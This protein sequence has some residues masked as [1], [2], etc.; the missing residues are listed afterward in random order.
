MSL[1]SRFSFFR[2]DVGSNKV[3]DLALPTKSTDPVVTA[4][5]Q[6]Q[7]INH[8]LID[9]LNT[10]T[11][12][13]DFILDLGCHVGTFSVPAAVLG[14]AVASLDAS[15]L[16]VDALRASIARNRLA[17]LLVFW[18]AVSETD[19]ELEFHENGLWGMV[20]RGGEDGGAERV[21]AKRVDSLLAELAWP[22]LDLVKMD[23]EGSEL[24]ALRSMSGMLTGPDA[25]AV[26]YE[27]NGMTFEIFKYSIFD[28][29]V[30]LE[31]HGYQT[32][33][34]EGGRFVYCPPEQLQPEAWL[35]VVALPPHWRT[36]LREQIVDQ[37]SDTA[38]TNRCLEWGASE[39]S[40][41]RKYLRDAM[42][43]ASA[44]YPRDDSRLSD[45][46]SNLNAEFG[47]T[48]HRR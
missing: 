13:G 24:F 23:V 37:W 18:C 38:M 19:G 16:H 34:V 20:S 26:I 10:L 9:L 12:P 45:L 31:D 48:G 4:Y 41:V 7:F 22:R 21:P 5:Q 17:N 2:I 29:R 27:S 44:N 28:I 14:R 40:N 39:H 15:R 30:F 36:T 8:Y 6:G 25:P 1:D 47:E 43:S 11:R 46:L 3:A 42:L 33:R 35:D 32:F